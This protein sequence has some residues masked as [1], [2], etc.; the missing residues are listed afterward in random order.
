MNTASSTTYFTNCNIHI[1][2]KNDDD[3]SVPVLSKCILSNCYIS[4]KCPSNKGLTVTCRNNVYNIEVPEGNI[5]FNGS[6]HAKTVINDSLIDA[7]YDNNNTINYLIKATEE[8]MHNA[9]YLKSQ[10]FPIA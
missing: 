4:G 9:E 8:Q 7:S 6:D 10:G 2:G 1:G 3:F 5:I